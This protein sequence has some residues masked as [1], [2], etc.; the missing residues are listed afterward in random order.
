MY[1][2]AIMGGTCAA[3]V[4]LVI[5]SVNLEDE[6][7]EGSTQQFLKT[8]GV[9]VGFTVINGAVPFLLQLLVRIEDY[10]SGSTEIYVTL[11][12][13]FSLRIINVYVLVIS[14]V[15]QIEKQKG[16]S[17]V[18]CGGTYI[19][20]E[21]FKVVILDTLVQAFL[22]LVIQ[23]GYYY[24]FDE[25]RVFRI[26]DAVLAIVYRQA[27]VWVGTFVCPWMPLIGVLSNFMFFLVYYYIVKLTCRPPTKR[28]SQSRNN[29]FYL[30]CL[31]ATLLFI[32]APVSVALTREAVPLAKAL[33]DCANCSCGPF[34]KPPPTAVVIELINS[35]PS[36]V[37]R[38]VL[39]DY[40][41]SSTAALPMIFITLCVIY[42]QYKRLQTEAFQKQLLIRELDKER[43]EK[44]M[45]IRTCECQ[46][47]KAYREGKVKH[48]KPL[49][50]YSTIIF[51]VDV[52]SDE[53]ASHT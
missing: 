49:R 42:Y 24:W 22:Q 2:R 8:Y 44:R 52:L 1:L 39:T 25:K 40:I 43:H 35:L 48:M 6:D 26:P 45:Y 50:R 34:E 17:G 10:V 28:W 15:V 18:E 14:L 16:D 20:Q 31:A 23:F 7:A 12:R 13:T 19:G 33:G 30:S 5:K 4:I 29:V 53:M 21:L 36:E 51:V 11:F 47:T 37:P 9:S 3:I 46:S 32:I 27:L 38:V 41:L